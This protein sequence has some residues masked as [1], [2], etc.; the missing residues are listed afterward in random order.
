MSDQAKQPQ[1]QLTIGQAAPVGAPQ[2]MTRSDDW[3]AVFANGFTFQFTAAD[4]GITFLT[5]VPTASGQ[6]SFQQSVTVN[7]T[8][9]YLKTISEHFALFVKIYEEELGEIKVSAHTRPNELQAESIRQIIRQGQ[10]T[11]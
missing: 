1:S 11:E 10:M 4:F 9:S 7:M 5:P 3:R 8:L 6:M 2:T